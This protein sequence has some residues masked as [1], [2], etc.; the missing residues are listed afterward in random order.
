MAACPA[1]L[2]P[3]LRQGRRA[4]QGRLPGQVRHHHHG[5]HDAPR[6]GDVGAAQEVHGESEDQVPDIPV[7][8]QEDNV[9]CGHADVRLEFGGGQ[10]HR[11]GRHLHP[12]HPNGRHAEA[13]CAEQMSQQAQT[14]GVERRGG[15]KRVDTIM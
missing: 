12:H 10:S 5:G 7:L 1:L 9:V 8:P 15:D 6:Q 14:G 3:Q 11:A 13:Q 2:L 4:E